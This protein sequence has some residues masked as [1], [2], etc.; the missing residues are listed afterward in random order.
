MAFDLH[1][2]LDRT[3]A[4]AVS[5]TTPQG[6]RTAPIAMGPFAIVAARLLAGIVAGAD[7][8][9]WLE[10]AVVERE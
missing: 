9:D 7:G 4:P 2:F 8:L 5:C 10:P 3:G 1:F 6:K